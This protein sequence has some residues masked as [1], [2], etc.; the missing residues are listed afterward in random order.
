MVSD[1]LTE[2]W[3][4]APVLD[5]IETGRYKELLHKGIL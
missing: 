5:A 4:T 2:Y 3:C 1:N